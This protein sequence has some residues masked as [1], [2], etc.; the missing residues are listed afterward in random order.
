MYTC[1][2][3]GHLVHMARTWRRTTQVAFVCMTRYAGFHDLL[4]LRRYSSMGSIWFSFVV[5][6]CS[7]N[8]Q[9]TKEG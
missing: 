7:M 2:N 9:N 4:S 1:E 5:R 8:L 3:E 6:A